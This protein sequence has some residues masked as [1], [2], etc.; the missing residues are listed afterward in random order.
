MMMEVF[1]VQRQLKVTYH[2]NSGFSIRV[3]GILLVFDYW[4]GESRR[5]SEVGRLNRGILGA[6]EQVY[7]FNG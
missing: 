7:I 4:E 1:F 5:L 2:Y 3:G 6:Y